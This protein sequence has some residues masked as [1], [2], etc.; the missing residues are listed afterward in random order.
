MK[1]ELNIFEETK[2]LKR[3]IEIIKFINH[4]QQVNSNSEK[5]LTFHK[6]AGI[7]DRMAVVMG[8]Q[9]A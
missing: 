5:K 4:S 8:E 9:L 2:M 6:P 3:R 7:N 1:G